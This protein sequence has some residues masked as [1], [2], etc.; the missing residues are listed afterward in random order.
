MT[1]QTSD[2]YQ[3][4]YLLKNPHLQT[5]L[6]SSKIRVLGTNPMRTVARERIIETDVGTKL[7]GYHS[8]QPVQPAKGLAVL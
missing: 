6:A 2:G 4:P 8:E 1:M 7:L 3:P 5:I